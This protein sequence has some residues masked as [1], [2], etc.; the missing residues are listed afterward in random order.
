MDW[1]Q[2]VT[3]SVVSQEL[4]LQP[5]VFNIFISDPQRDDSVCCHR[6]IIYF[7]SFAENKFL[8]HSIF[9]WNDWIDCHDSEN[10]VDQSEH[11]LRPWIIS[12][13]P[14]H[15]YFWIISCSCRRSRVC[16]TYE[17]TLC[18]LLLNF[19]ILFFSSF[20]WICYVVYEICMKNFICVCVLITD[21][22]LMWVEGEMVLRLYLLARTVIN[23]A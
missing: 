3:A 18:I 17:F 19:Y 4:I 6:S 5:V 9:L 13:S 7:Y 12:K 20:N 15:V 21:A 23:L 16:E 2:A 14:I 8:C 10:S 22:V 11:L 1:T